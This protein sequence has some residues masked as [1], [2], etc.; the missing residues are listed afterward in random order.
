MSSMTELFLDDEMIE[1]AAGVVRRIHQ[2]AKHR[3]NPVMQAEKWW[4]GNQLF[5]YCTMYDEE[6]K[7]FKMWCR[8]GS[9]SPEKRVDGHGACSTY[10]TSE[11]GVHWERPSLG[12][13]DFGGRRDHNVIFTGDETENLR[14]QGKKGVIISVV[15]NPHARDVDEKYVGMG[16]QL[17]KRGAYLGYSADGIHWRFD[18][19]PFWQSR[20][21]PTSW[22]DDNLKHL[23]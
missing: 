8:C 5:P 3:L 12:L 2:P 1:M 17:R 16:F 22:G 10:V 18:D 14:P 13:M 15:R 19:E 23:I 7:L 9:D 20:I 4:E 21:D 6:E 11:D